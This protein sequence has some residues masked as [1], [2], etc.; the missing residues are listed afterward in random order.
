MTVTEQD[1]NGRLLVLLGQEQQIQLD[2]TALGTYTELFVVGNSQ[3]PSGASGGRCVV[4][5]IFV[6]PT[7]GTTV[8]GSNIIVKFGAGGGL[9]D[10]LDRSGGGPGGS[11]LNI[12]NQPAPMLFYPNLGATLSAGNL[13][14]VYSKGASFGFTNA[15]GVTAASCICTISVYG[16]NE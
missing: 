14:P 6:T 2:Q 5:Y 4:A 10:W 16:W 11:S 9:N 15:A 12:Q 1:V 7:D 13:I 8:F 3:W